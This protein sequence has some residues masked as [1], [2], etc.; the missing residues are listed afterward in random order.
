MFAGLLNSGI[1]VAWVLLYLSKNSEWKQKVQA[2]VRAAGAKYGDKDA[3]LIDQLSAIPVAGWESEFPM[4][5]LCLR[6]SIRLQLLGAAFRRNISGHDIPINDGEEVIPPGAYVTYHLGDVHLNPA[7]YRDPEV[8]DPSRYQAD[9]AEDKKQSHA[10]V[11]WG[12]G[13]HPCLG[14]RFAKLE[15]NVITAFFL[16]MYDFELVDGSGKPKEELPKVEFNSQTAVKPKE[17]VFLKIRP[18]KA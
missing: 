18:V 14:M 9:R 6:D 10:Y 5:D 4:L 13:R 17:K 15:Q 2:E 11:G 8:W 1:N 3:S 16:A 12:T 7:I